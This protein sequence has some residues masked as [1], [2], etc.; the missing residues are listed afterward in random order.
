M[1]QIVEKC[2]D[3]FAINTKYKCGII[4]TQT[5]NFKLSDERVNNNK[6]P[7]NR[8]QKPKSYHEVSHRYIY[9]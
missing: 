7:F 4:S 1:Q 2:G 6:I 8:Q 3:R 5:T 9:A